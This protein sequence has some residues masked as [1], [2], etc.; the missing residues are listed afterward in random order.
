M[1]FRRPLTPEP[2]ETAEDLLARLADSLAEPADPPARRSALLLGAPASDAWYL[3]SLLA[4]CGF[5]VDVITTPTRHFRTRRH[6]RNLTVVPTADAV[7]AVGTERTRVQPYDWV[8]SVNDDFLAKLRTAT[9]VPADARVRLAPVVDDDSLAWLSS[10]TSVARILSEAG[11]P[12]PRFEVVSGAAVEPTT[13]A[14]E[15]K[16]VESASR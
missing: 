3:P 1:R 6:V 5:D 15:A 13:A 8:V 7:L 10:K 12:T 4:R 11:L 2:G 9:D 16:L 14:V